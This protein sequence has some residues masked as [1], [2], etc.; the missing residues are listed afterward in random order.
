MGVKRTVNEHQ[1]QP[2]PEGDQDRPKPSAG[3]RVLARCYR[4]ALHLIAGL[5][6]GVTIVGLVL[7]WQLSKGPISLSFLTPY[8]E[9]RLNADQPEMKISMGDTILTWA[10]WERALDIRVLDVEAVDRDGEVVAS[11][12]EIS[13][14]LSTT[15]LIRRGE[16]VPKTIDLFGPS[17][18]M[19]RNRD[20]SLELDLGSPSGERNFGGGLFDMLFETPSPESPLAFLSRLSVIGA[21]AVIEDRVLNRLWIAPV[22]DIRL[23]RDALGIAGEVSLQMDLGGRTSEINAEGA[24]LSKDRRLNLSIDFAELDPQTLAD[25]HPDLRRLAGLRIPLK[26]QV[27]LGMS[28]D[29]LPDEVGFQLSGGPGR[30]ELPAPVAQT[31]EIEELVLDGYYDGRAGVGEVH[32][33]VI[34]TP[35]GTTVAVPGSES[36][37]LPLD[38][39]SFA[40][41][42]LKD[43]DRLE[44]A[45]LQLATGGPMVDV[46]GAVDEA[47]GAAVA[48]FDIRIRDVPLKGVDRYW[49]AEWAP[50]VYDWWTENVSAG[51]V[52]KLAMKTRIE[53]QSA[54]WRLVSAIGEMEI[55]DATVSYLEGMPPVTDVT[56][57]ADFTHKRFDLFVTGGRSQGMQVE[58]GLIFLTG[59]DRD[60][61]RA[62]ITVN[63]GGDLDKALALIDHEPLGYATQMGIDPKGATGSAK[64]RL[65]VDLPLARDLPLDDVDIAAEA[66]LRGA[67]VPGALHGFDL[68][69][70]DL[71][72]SID[73]KGMDVRG[74]GA[75][76]NIPAELSWRENFGDTAA[77]R[78]ILDLSGRVPDMQRIRDLNLELGPIDDDY[79][80]GPFTADLRFTVLKDRDTRIEIRADL[81]EASVDVPKFKWSK[82]AGVA[83]R[84]EINLS[85][86]DTKVKK[87]DH[88]AV[89]AEDLAV[90]GRIGFDHDTADM[91]RIDF[92][93]IL[94]GRTDMKGALIRRADGAWDVGFHGAGL[95]LS[96][97]W[98]E[99]TDNKD[100]R[101]IG[102]F[103][104]AGE[105]DKV[106]LDERK[107]L[108]NVSATFDH[109]GDVWRTVLL[110]SVLNKDVAVNVTLQPGAD[111]NRELT[112]S[113]GDAGEVLR[114]V[115]VYDNMRGGVLKLT[116]KFDDSHPDRP[117]DGRMVIRDY[118]V[119]RAPALAHL[120][121]I[122]ALTGILDALQGDGL[123]F[124]V[125]DIPFTMRR[126][127]VEIRNA[128]A[129]GTSLGFTASG[130]LYTDADVVDLQGTVV[131][132]YALNSALG[133]IPLLGGLITGGEKGSGLF[134][135]NFR[136]T[137]RQED[138]DVNVNPLSV[139]T[140]GFLR[141]LFGVFGDPTTDP[142]SVGSLDPNADP[143][144]ASP[145]PTTD[146]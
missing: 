24:Y 94:F 134:A 28:I 136:L 6:A 38:G 49:A 34:K 7:A 20:G 16:I 102:N 113:T 30:I 22:A 80:H 72:M 129:A 18:T 21:E 121:S 25:F 138:P 103:V 68:S 53:K 128:R 59:I 98:A 143:A 133:R 117:L 31:V 71:D 12:P 127:V 36:H 66:R 104:F 93:Q 139:L 79:V 145:T 19:R 144:T 89:Y 69:D 4:G 51:Q 100:D 96:P 132:A 55:K 62:E 75:V 119:T 131:P 110:R 44:I 97:F 5:T 29:G 40:G 120:V 83:G 1:D 14:S 73:K 35:E 115:K 142:A 107:V 33:F 70:A 124:A 91:R 130:A 10:G 146:P 32:E 27:A 43:V 74:Y 135:A 99:M 58:D 92:S 42:Y 17:L 106:W 52:P 56:G 2:T 125:L 47:T 57:R 123:G 101:E 65:K 82:P 48:D 61:E 112:V 60:Q 63:L 26:G 109:A 45:R 84:A 114:A 39:L 111:G 50:D 108:S 141:K 54:G 64:V 140:P 78:T 46:S 81:E 126:G 76:A 85:L 23:T 87:I 15:A 118:R 77:F 95:D 137:G 41:K 13:F 8:I 11:I 122:M 3:G 90:A 67:S 86:R 116:G 9:D 88:F 37:R 105:F